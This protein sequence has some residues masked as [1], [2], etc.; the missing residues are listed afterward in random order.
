MC[1]LLIYWSVGKINVTS[2]GSS[3]T[4]KLKEGFFVFNLLIVQCCK[5]IFFFCFFQSSFLKTRLAKFIT[6]NFTTE[7][8]AE[9]VKMFFKEH[10]FAGTER[11]VSQSVETIQLNSAW[12]QRDLEPIRNYFQKNR[13]NK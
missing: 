4:M 8:R 5:P 3:S 13:E 12:L 9:E 1:L 11:T 7:E 2:Q 6:E 10:P